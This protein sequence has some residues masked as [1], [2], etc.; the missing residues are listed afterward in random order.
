MSGWG[1]E[2]RWRDARFP[3]LDP[4][5]VLGRLRSVAGL[6]ADASEALLVRAGA[7]RAH[8][9][10][11]IRTT[12]HLLGVALRAEAR[13]RV[14]EGGGPRVRLDLTGRE[15]EQLRRWSSVLCERLL[16]A[17]A[18]AA[19]PGL[20]GAPAELTTRSATR[21]LAHDD[22]ADARASSIA[23]THLCGTC[24]RASSPERGVVRPDLRHHASDR[25]R[26]VDSGVFPGNSGA[27]PKTS[28]L[29]IA[30]L[31]ARGIVRA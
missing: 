10:R 2:R 27:N 11:P 16:A 19:F 24:R 31:G 8:L 13:G 3:A 6:D 7:S 26:V 12:L 9:L 5:L 14:S 28:P 20:E 17:D 15:V 18:E 29:A 23:A 1:V 30:T 22:P 4:P 25:L 21:R